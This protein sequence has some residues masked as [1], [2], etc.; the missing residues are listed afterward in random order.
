MLIR[1]I[2]FQADNDLSI[3]SPLLR[4][5]GEGDINIGED[6]LNYLVKASVVGTSKGQ[7]GRDVDDLKGLT[8]PVRLS[9]P[10]TAPKYTID[11][12]AMVTDVAKQKVEE[13]LTSEIGKRLGGSAAAGG[14]A[15]GTTS[16]DAAAK[17]AG[18]SSSGS[19]AQDALKGLF[20]R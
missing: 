15:A 5:G 19:R 14:T 4:V 12:G 18:K 9:G 20:G 1:R 16:K 7:G 10:L 8:V 6:S 2:Y 13:R 17:D 11:F 3:K